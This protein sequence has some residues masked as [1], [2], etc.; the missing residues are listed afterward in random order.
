MKEDKD[1]IHNWNNFVKEVK[2]AFSDKNKAVD[3][4]WKI[5][6]L[7]Q[8]KNYI[9]DFIIKFEVLAIKAKTNDIDAIFLLKKNIRSNIIKNILGYLLIAAPESLKEQKVEITL[10][11]QEYKSTKGRQ[12]Y[13][14][15]SEI[16][17]G[18]RG[19]PVTILA[20]SSY[21]T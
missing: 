7:N 5:E 3:A 11:R 13:R 18:G 8:G 21:C 16:T 9:V 20:Q 6:M 10:V 19:V 4:E 2:I 17:C 1:N 12:D 15:G 14:T